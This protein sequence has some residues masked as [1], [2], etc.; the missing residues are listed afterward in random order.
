MGENTA[1]ENEKEWQEGAARN[2]NDRIH[3]RIRLH[4]WPGCFKELLTTFVTFEHL[5]EK[6]L[7]DNGSERPSQGNIHEAKCQ[8]LRRMHGRPRIYDC[9]VLV[10]LTDR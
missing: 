2:E 4:L 6:L 1:Y 3:E 7:C 10:A 9:P 5:L 8:P